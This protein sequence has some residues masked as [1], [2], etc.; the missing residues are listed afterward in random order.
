MDR[1]EKVS[2]LRAEAGAL[3]KANQLEQAKEKFLS[4]LAL[5]PG[6]VDTLFVLAQLCEVQRRFEEALD[7]LSQALIKKPEIAMLWMRRGVVHMRRG[8]YDLAVS[9][10]EHAVKLAPNSADMLN[11]LGI[12]YSQSQRK[13]KRTL[14][15]K[16]FER[17]VGL[18]PQ[19]VGMLNNYGNILTELGRPREALPVFERARQLAPNH[20]AIH[21]NLGQTFSALKAFAQAEPHFRRAIE[22]KFSFAEAHENLGHSLMRMKRY[23]EA[24][25]SF[26]DALALMGQTTPART[27]VLGQALLA[28]MYLCDDEDFDLMWGE[29]VEGLRRGGSVYSPFP[30]LALTD[31]PG[32]LR[33]IHERYVKTQAFSE[34]TFV[35]PQVR[36]PGRIRLGYF[37]GDFHDHAT[38][39]LMA[40]LFEH[41]DRARFELVAF[42][43]GPPSDGPWRRRAVAAFD[44]FLDVSAMTTTE[45]VKK[46]REVELD[47]AIDLKGFTADHRAEIFAQRVAPIQINFLGYPSTMGMS[48]MDYILADE[49]II[50][51]ELRGFYREE[52]LNLPN[53]YQPNCR[54]RDISTEPMTR[55]EFGLPDE[56]EG[57]FVY[58]SFNA[59]YK[60]TPEMFRCW[61]DILREVDGSVLWML[62]TDHDARENLRRRASLHGVDPS[63]VI[64]ADS[65]PVDKH[66]ARLRFA[67]LMLDTFPYNA[68][69]TAS[70]ALRVGLPVLTRRGRSFPSR[71]AASLILTAGEGAGFVTD[72][73]AQYR[74]IAVSEGRRPKGER[75]R[76]EGLAESVL[77]DAARFA[78]ALEQRLKR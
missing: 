48:S 78:L 2:S 63:R 23:R 28:K 64:F 20:A 53:S 33:E 1:D 40:E 13:N 61:L 76:A 52:V 5:R 3:V 72:D 6:D 39:H 71:V 49:V 36:R 70:D 77:F 73:I 25:S 17:S 42:S 27:R 29:L 24:L 41:H 51:A 68:H 26:K 30:M 15:L 55:A 69:T 31:D 4:I 59:H 56:I 45:L 35:R 74:D 16:V 54:Q 9:D 67:D 65:V 58:A 14:A 46:A 44:S 11:E 8:D 50:P 32:L 19:N 62:V 37:S 38:M 18:A 12:A 47:I 57:R 34:D 66:L 22:L 60:I 21:H 7:Y 10:L 43:F 75:V